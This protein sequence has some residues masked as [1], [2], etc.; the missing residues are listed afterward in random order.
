M[1]HHHSFKLDEN[2]CIDLWAIIRN[3]RFETLII[4][5]YIFY[6]LIFLFNCIHFD[7]L[8]KKCFNNIKKPR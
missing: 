2:K 7:A 1:F 3:D 8:L 4:H 5:A 6:C